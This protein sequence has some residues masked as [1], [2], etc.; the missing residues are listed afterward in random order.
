MVFDDE[1]RLAGVERLG[2]RLD[3]QRRQLLTVKY[4]DREPALRQ[5]LLGGEGQVRAE[6]RAEQRDRARLAYPAT[7]G[8]L[9]R[10]RFE[11]AA[12]QT[13]VGGTVGGED[14]AHRE[15]QVGGVARRPDL[16]VRQRR[17][18]RHVVQRGVRLPVP[19]RAPAGVR[20]D[21]RHRL[22]A[23][24]QA[25]PDL[26]V[27]PVAEER[28]EGEDP[29]PQP[30]TGH[31]GGHRDHALLGDAGHREPLREPLGEMDRAVRVGQVAV[32]HLDAR[33]VERQLTQILPAVIRHA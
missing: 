11:R 4:T 14:A 13:Q 25:H 12:R 10:Q 20:A 31:P 5:H 9:A 15:P 16:H 33:V 30:A 26:V 3:G 22:A 24:A 17:H 2:Q 8:G 23:L 29:R 28:A 32:E 27:G 6:T 18:E 7:H 19:R 21:E 1:D